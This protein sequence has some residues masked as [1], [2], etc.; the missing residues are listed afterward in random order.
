LCFGVAQEKQ[1]V[2]EVYYE[3]PDLSGGVKESTTTSLR[4]IC[5]ICM[6]LATWLILP[7]F[8]NIRCFK[9]MKQMYLDIF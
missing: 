6:L 1:E 3:E 7:P 4:K 2:E 8:I 9:F 5:D